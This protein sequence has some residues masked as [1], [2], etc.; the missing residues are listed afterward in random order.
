MYA[1]YGSAIASLRPTVRTNLVRQDQ[2]V[3]KERGEEKVN[4]IPCRN[5][6]VTQFENLGASFGNKRVSS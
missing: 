4:F 2:R 3:T 5:L 6:E 1:G